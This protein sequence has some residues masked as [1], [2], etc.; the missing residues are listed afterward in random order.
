MNKKLLAIVLSALVAA[1]LASAEASVK[2][3]TV[4]PTLAI[5]DTAIDTSIPS[6]KNR[7]VYEVCILAWNTCP[8]GTN[9]QEGAGSASLPSSIITRNGFDHGTQMA[10]VAAQSNL[11]MNILFVR[12]IGNTRDGR[13]QL[14]PEASI[15]NALS[16]IIANKDKYNVQ[17]VTMAQGNT[18]YNKTG[19]YCPASG[20]LTQVV[21]NA[22]ASNLPV[23]FPAGNDRNYTRINWPACIPAA[24]AVGGTDTTGAVATWSNHDPQRLDFYSLGQTRAE[25]PGGATINVAGTSV[26]IQTAAAN[27]LKLKSVKPALSVGDINAL[28][29]KTATPTSNSKVTSIL[30]NLGAAING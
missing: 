12:I 22:I 18:N 16:W 8:N 20:P 21:N 3:K 15:A 28:I 19:D 26:A 1:P 23:F 2:N 17:A 29:A 14:T 9:F 27:W 7:V 10:S 11:N 30:F 25:V 24:I 4:L 5:M 6:L 13:R